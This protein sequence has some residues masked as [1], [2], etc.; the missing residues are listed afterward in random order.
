M[1]TDRSLYIDSLSFSRGGRAILSG[2][3]LQVPSNTVIGIL[4]R[5]GSGKSTLMNCIFGSSK[6]D[7]AFMKCD[8]EVF[9]RGYLT[10]EITYLP[11]HGFVPKSLSVRKCIE[12]FDLQNS[13]LTEIPIIQQHMNFKLGNL[14]LGFAKLFEDLLILYS[15]A[16]YSL[17]DEPFVG[18]SPM[19]IELF[20]EH[21]HDRRP[22]KGILISDHYYHDVMD[23]SDEMYLMKEGSLLK[24]KDKEDL[25]LHQYLNMFD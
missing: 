3:Y 8:G 14:S 16:N 10:K 24:I 4:G 18:L 5:N 2:V 12:L 1:C 13:L 15:N 17:F 22:H 19:Y 21:L 11:Q 7:F 23:V 9:R 25:V 20:K 6:P